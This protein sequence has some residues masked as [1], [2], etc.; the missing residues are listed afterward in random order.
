MDRS[1]RVSNKP[2]GMEGLDHQLYG[3][4]QSLCSGE[5]HECSTMVLPPFWGVG[6]V[7][8]F[9]RIRICMVGMAGMVEK[10]GR[11]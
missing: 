9:F 11:T 7:R 10:S 6:G 1:Y 4:V 8:G 3:M 5:V 2:C